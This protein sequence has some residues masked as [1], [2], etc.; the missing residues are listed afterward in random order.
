MIPLQILSVLSICIFRSFYVATTALFI[1]YA[2]S[3]G[4]FGKLYGVTRVI[5]G[6]FTMLSVPI[7]ETVQAQGNAFKSANFD[8]AVVTGKLTCQRATRIITVR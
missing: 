7:F 5:G 3:S 2:F 8:F 1:S 6:L 4:H